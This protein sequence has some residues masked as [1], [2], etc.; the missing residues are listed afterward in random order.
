MHCKLFIKRGM[1]RQLFTKMSL[2]KKTRELLNG[3]FSFPA[4][5]IYEYYT[6]PC[7]SLVFLT[8]IYSRQISY[9]KTINYFFEM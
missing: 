4:N 2:R 6:I 5:M 7:Q 1:R 3:K 9:L 8:L